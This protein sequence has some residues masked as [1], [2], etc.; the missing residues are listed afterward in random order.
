LAF[1]SVF[2]RKSVFYGAFVWLHRALNRHFR[3]FSA[4]AVAQHDGVFAAGMAAVAAF[5]LPSQLPAEQL[6]QYKGLP[7][8]HVHVRPIVLGINVHVP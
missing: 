1:L 4:R 6:E 8:H 3:W 2:H 7:V 5:P